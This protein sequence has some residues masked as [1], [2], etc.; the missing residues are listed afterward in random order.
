MKVYRVRSQSGLAFDLARRAGAGHRRAVLQGGKYIPSD[1]QRRLGAGEHLSRPMGNL[2]ATSAAAC[3]G[4]AASK[5]RAPTTWTRRGS[6]SRCTGASAPSRRSRSWK[7]A[8]FE[9]D[10]YWLEAGAVLRDTTIEGHNLTL[11]RTVRTALIQSRDRDHRRDRKRPTIAPRT[12]CC[13]TT[14]TSASRS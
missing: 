1:P 7:R 3:C 14:S 10:E 13:S 11:T 8:G 6:F 4:P 12:T 2:S 5:T 9:G